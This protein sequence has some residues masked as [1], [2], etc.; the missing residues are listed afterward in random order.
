MASARSLNAGLRTSEVPNLRSN[1]LGKG[2][3]RGTRGKN[4]NNLAPAVGVENEADK[5]KKDGISPSEF[6]GN[7]FASKAVCS[8][9][10][11]QEK[12]VKYLVCTQ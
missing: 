11:F 6:E 12:N 5:Q 7:D 8:L 2:R 4:T 9:H 1:Y 3:G 10:L